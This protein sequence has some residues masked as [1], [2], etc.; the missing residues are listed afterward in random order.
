MAGNRKEMALDLITAAKGGIARPIVCSRKGS[1]KQTGS[2]A[3]RGLGKGGIN[4]EQ[5]QPVGPRAF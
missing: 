5:N 1:A 3:S 4:D 2:Q